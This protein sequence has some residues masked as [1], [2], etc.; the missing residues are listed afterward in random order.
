M[1]LES[2]VVIVSGGA[3]GL[4]AV[5]ARGIV[6]EG[7]SVVIGDLLEDE[8]RAVAAELGERAHFVRLDV[9]EPASW[10]N[11]V[12][13]AESEYGALHGLVNNA[14][15]SAPGVPAVEE[16]LESFRRVIE[17]NLVGVQLGM[18]HA[19]PALRRA[20]GGSIVNISSIAG[21]VGMAAS[22]SYGAAKWAVRGLSKV[23]A[24]ELAAER[25]RVNS[26][27]P[28]VIF[29]PMTAPTGVTVGEGGYPPAAI[30]RVGEPEELVG[31]VVYLLSD[32][33]SYTTGAELIVDGG[34]TAGPSG[35]SLALGF[36]L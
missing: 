6:R 17:T 7:G 21:I 9:T 3:R 15:I 5:Y 28:G 8:G 4:G 30:G 12:A 35:A 23:A 27:H 14:G 33:A 19:V 18:Q 26:V 32:R 25:I 29:T 10:V 2:K 1:E 36:R 22:G 20:G 24:V 16:S 13:V 34:H 31:A 11:A